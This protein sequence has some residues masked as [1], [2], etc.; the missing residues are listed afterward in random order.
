MGE[1]ITLPREQKRRRK[2]LRFLRKQVEDSI[3]RDRMIEKDGSS[4]REAALL[5]LARV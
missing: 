2:C 5:K 4:S 1:Q 3:V